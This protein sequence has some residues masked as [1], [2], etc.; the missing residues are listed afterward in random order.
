METECTLKAADTVKY[1]TALLCF[2]D[3]ASQLCEVK[4]IVV[5]K[6]GSEAN[7]PDKLAIELGLKTATENA[8]FSKF[9][10]TAKEIF[11]EVPERDADKILGKFRKTLNQDTAYARGFRCFLKKAA[12]PQSAIYPDMLECLFVE[13]DVMS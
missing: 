13:E 10:G 5:E 9:K 1:S 2:V 8:A 3:A 4:R 6:F 12:S 11:S 7:S